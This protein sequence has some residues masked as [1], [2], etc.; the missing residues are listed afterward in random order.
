MDNDSKPQGEDVLLSPNNEPFFSDEGV[1][2][3]STNDS[4]PQKKRTVETR[5]WKIIEF[6]KE[7]PNSN[8]Y[9]IA[10][11]IQQPYNLV[12]PSLKTLV[13]ARVL[14]VRMGFDSQQRTVEVFFLPEK[15]E[16]KQD[17]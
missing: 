5:T 15:K 8:A 3:T 1:F 10:K 2:T 7:N 6:V 4:T 11:G 9:Q 17:G 16:K 12:L 14:C 13:F